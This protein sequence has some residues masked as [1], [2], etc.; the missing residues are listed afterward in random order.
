MTKTKKKARV[1]REYDLEKG[2]M[3][4]TKNNK[5]YQFAFNGLSSRVF[6]KLAMIGAGS[7][8]CKH[9][10][11]MAQWEKICQNLF[12][13]E[14]NY[15]RIPKIIHAY[16]RLNQIPI[17]TACKQYKVMSKSEKAAIKSMPDIKKTLLLMKLEEIDA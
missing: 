9:D 2:I 13:R 4:M 6:M 12:G 5:E 17:E 1:K 11:P 8:L 15:S 16:A 10:K 7:I 14:R 3:T